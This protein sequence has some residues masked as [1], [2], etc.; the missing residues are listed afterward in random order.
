MAGYQETPK[1][2]YRKSI[3]SIMDSREGVDYHRAYILRSFL[4]KL[5]MGGNGVEHYITVSG[6]K[7]ERED[8]SNAIWQT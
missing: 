4:A 6:S 3:F 1:S 8:N 5:I 2:F 7:I